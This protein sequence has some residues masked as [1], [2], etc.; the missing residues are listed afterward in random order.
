MYNPDFNQ[1][2]NENSTVCTTNIL[3][4][5][6]YY[7]NIHNPQ[8]IPCIACQKILKKLKGAIS[9]EIPLKLNSHRKISLIAPRVLK[10]LCFFYFR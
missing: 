9:F 6:N 10:I 7:Q 3:S 4:N 5:K 2:I 8:S 1:K